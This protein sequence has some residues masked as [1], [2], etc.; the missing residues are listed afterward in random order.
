MAP[1]LDMLGIVTKDIAASV[2]F[3]RTLGLDIPDPQEGEPYHETNLPGGLRISWNDVEMVKQIDPEWVEPVGQ[4]LGVAFLCDGSAG[5]DATYARL[6]AAG[7]KGH[8]EPW[9][10]FWGQRYAMVLDP[11]GMGIDLFAPLG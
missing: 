3:Y 9:D 5:V 7:Y 6:I 4:R 2:R 1:K 11:D 8:R 10:A